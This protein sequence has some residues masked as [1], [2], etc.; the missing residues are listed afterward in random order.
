[1]ASE[2]IKKALTESGLRFT[3]DASGTP[4]EPGGIIHLCL[5][6]CYDTGCAAGYCHTA[7]ALGCFA[8]CLGGCDQ[9][10]ACWIGCFYENQRANTST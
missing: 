9:G 5:L 1:M 4:E 7:C 2:E 3:A 6:G 8:T 10:G